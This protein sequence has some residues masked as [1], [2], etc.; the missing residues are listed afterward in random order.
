MAMTFKQAKEKLA[1]IADGRYSS[2][3]YEETF[4][5]DGT[6]SIECYVYIKDVGWTEGET[7]ESVFEKLEDP[8]KK[9]KGQPE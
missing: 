7:W 9:Y 3:R 4:H 5:D 8:D 6:V 2:I 1:K